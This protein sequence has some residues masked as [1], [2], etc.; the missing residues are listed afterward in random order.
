[1]QPFP[2]MEKWGRPGLFFRK[3]EIGGFSDNGLYVI[4]F[5]KITIWRIYLT[6][7]VPKS[8]MAAKNKTPS[9]STYIPSLFIPAK[10]FISL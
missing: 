8:T 1:M 4:A 9:S 7:I 3:K 10:F 5:V 6:Q 2:G